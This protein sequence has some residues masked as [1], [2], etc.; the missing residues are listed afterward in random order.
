MI[1]RLLAAPLPL[2]TASV[3]GIGVPA[4]ILAAGAGRRLQPVTAHLAKPLVPVLNVP[5]LYWSIAGLVGAGASLVVANVHWFAEQLVAAAE[6]LYRRDGV[7][8]RLVTESRLTGP[9]GGLAGCREALPEADCYVVIGGDA[10]TD[11]DL[12]ALVRHHRRG[13][14][15]LTIMATTVADPHRFG[16]L[17]LRGDEIVGLREK[18]ADALPGAVV[19]CGIYVVSARALALLE[20]TQDDYDFKHVVPALLAGGHR[21]LAYRTD[22]YWTDI[23]DHDTYLATNLRALGSDMLMTATKATQVYPGLWCQGDP[24]LSARLA[25]DGTS[26]V[27]ARAQISSTALLD[28]VVI[29]PGAQVGASA[30]VRRS[31]LLPGAVVP[32]GATV[33]E[34]VIQ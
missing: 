12:S 1:D 24:S 3:P 18:P 23:G 26:L 31:V 28:Q 9:A 4:V 5:L 21:V 16:V 32:D 19:S 7:A 6:C 27:D 2:Q 22:A 29:G 13:G 20:P 33:I 25:V 17:E 34:E 14:A 11:A 10:W 30:T 15:E 8:L